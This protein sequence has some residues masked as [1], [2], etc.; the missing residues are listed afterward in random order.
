MQTDNEVKQR[1]GG[2][3]TRIA[4]KDG[5]QRPTISDNE[6]TP[7]HDEIE[8]ISEKLAYGKFIKD[9]EFETIKVFEQENIEEHKN[10]KNIETGLRMT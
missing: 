9:L 2:V 5:I 6:T 4:N 3:P 7:T 10:I 1:S 8:T